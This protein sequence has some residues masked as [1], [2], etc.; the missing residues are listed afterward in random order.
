MIK[1][2]RLHYLVCFW[3]LQFLLA[4]EVVAD[5]IQVTGSAPY[6]ESNYTQSREMAREDA[7]KQA[8]MRFGSRVSS[9]QRM[10]NGV[11]TSDQVSISSDTRILRSRIQNEYIWK[12]QLKLVMDVELE[13]QPEC[14]VTTG[15][16]YLKTVAVL[17]FP[18]QLPEQS[19]LG[20][21]VDIDRGFA[22]AL[23]QRLHERGNVVVYENSH[24]R[25][26]GELINAPSRYTQQHTLTN[27]ADFAKDIGVQFVVSGVIRDIGVADKEAF[28]TS[29]WSRLTRFTRHANQKRRFAVDLFIH[30][31]FSGAI[32]WQRNFSIEAKWDAEPSE[33]IGFGSTEFWH[34]SYG[35]AVSGLIADMSGLIEDQLRCQP[36]MTRVSRVNGKTLHFSSG[37]D[38]GIRPGDKFSLYRTSNFFDAD[39]LK[40]VELTN[41]KTA[42]TVSQVHPGF[43]SGTISVDPGRLNIQEDDLLIAW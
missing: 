23:S 10:E 21:L 13:E 42:L 38:T 31:G 30:D 11:I 39:Q 24:E 17:K 19:R 27:A 7:F 9:E 29:Y 1:P 15:S 18:L 22:S 33:K 16:E 32:V 20:E 28:S 36:F 4:S 26:P 34:G 35:Q 3:A 8:A 5:W 41:V 14:P 25:L 40:G 2:L 37:A 6:M 43:S 12:G